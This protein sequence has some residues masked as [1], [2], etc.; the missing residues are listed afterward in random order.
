MKEPIM[1]QKLVTSS[2]YSI[3]IRK[4]NSVWISSTKLNDM[5]TFG[6]LFYVPNNNLSAL[7]TTAVFTKLITKQ[8][9]TEWNT[10]V[11]H[12][13]PWNSI[14]GETELWQQK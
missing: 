5:L 10:T 6:P 1:V 11:L 4:I 3:K 7:V 12:I 9:S 8:L 13:K 14:G 2:K